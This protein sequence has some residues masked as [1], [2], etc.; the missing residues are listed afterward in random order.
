MLAEMEGWIVS[1]TTL[2]RNQ[3][4]IRLF[5]VHETDPGEAVAAVY[6]QVRPRD[7]QPVEILAPLS[8]RAVE[9]LDLPAGEAMELTPSP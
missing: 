3:P 8:A 2:G 1:I 5:A 6:R 9:A 4:E 7:D